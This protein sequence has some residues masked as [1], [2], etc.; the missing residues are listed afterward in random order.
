MNTR[1]LGTDLTVSAVGL[2]CMG[3]SHAYG[4]PTE[5]N[6]AIRSIRAAYDLGYTMFD[7]AE[8]YGTAAD[9]HHNEKILGKALSGIRDNQEKFLNARRIIFVACGTSWHA[10]LIGEYLLEDFCR[11]PVEVE[12][13]SEFRY[14]NPV[15]YPDDIVIAVSQSGETADTLAAIELAKQSGAFV[16]GVCNVVGYLGART[17]FQRVVDRPN[18]EGHVGVV[19]RKEPGDRTLKL[20]MRVVD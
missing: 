6:E 20:H 3:F 7:T 12:Y 5:K 16:Y 15:I 14:R 10:S 2:G 1:I 11:I 9:P 19:G 18:S 17:N 13:A 4:A 8:T